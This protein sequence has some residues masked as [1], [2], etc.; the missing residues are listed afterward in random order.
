MRVSFTFF[1]AHNLCSDE[2]NLL[3]ERTSMEQHAGSINRG[4]LSIS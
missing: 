4:G 1:S 3:T 2:E